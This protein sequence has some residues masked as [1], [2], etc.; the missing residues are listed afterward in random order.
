MWMTLP[1]FSWRCG[2]DAS[3]ELELQKL[4]Y[5]ETRKLWLNVCFLGT[6]NLLDFLLSQVV[7]LAGRGLAL[8]VP[9]LPVQGTKISFCNVYLS[10]NHSLFFFFFSKCL[11][12]SLMLP[13]VLFLLKL[14]IVFFLPCLLLFFIVGL[15]QNNQK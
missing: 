5:T 8:R 14:H 15:H 12:G 4:Q 7:C 3:P 10:K 6:G 11:Y 13:V 1:S 9:F 2:I